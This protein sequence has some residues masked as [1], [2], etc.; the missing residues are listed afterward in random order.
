M[1]KAP[2]TGAASAV[3]IAGGGSSCLT[4]IGLTAATTNG[5]NSGGTVPQGTYLRLCNPNARV[6]AMN[7]AGTRIFPY[8]WPRNDRLEVVKYDEVRPVWR[9]LE[10]VVV[11]RNVLVS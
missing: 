1:I 6:F 9:D 11:A 5:A 3:V 7:R 8:F 10:N 2:T 4:E